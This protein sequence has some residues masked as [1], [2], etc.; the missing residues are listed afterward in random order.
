VTPVTF[1]DRGTPLPG[2]ALWALHMPDNGVA[3]ASDGKGSM[4]FTVQDDGLSWAQ[5]RI[6]GRT[7]QRSEIVTPKP[8]PIAAT[9]DASYRLMVDLTGMASRDQAYIALGQIQNV[10]L[11]GDKHTSAPVWLKLHGTNPDGTEQLWLETWSEAEGQR[12]FG[13]F[14]YRLGSEIAVRIRA[15][16]SVK[17]KATLWLDGKPVASEAMPLGF[18]AP[19]AQIVALGIYTGEA[20]LPVGSGRAIH[21]GYRGVQIGVTP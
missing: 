19:H 10:Y 15:L 13:P 17:G 14:P 7:C 21:A 5:D 3:M 16:V 4:R 12:Q 1:S 2:G 20:G 6:D 9:I 8:L 11:P 18:K